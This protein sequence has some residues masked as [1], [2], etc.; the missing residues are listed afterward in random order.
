MPHTNYHRLALLQYPMGATCQGFRWPGATVRGVAPASAPNS[1]GRH[2]RA[3]V[4]PYPLPV[5][6]ARKSPQA[7]RGNLVPAGT[8]STATRLPRRCTP[9]DDKP[10]THEA[11]AM[12]GRSRPYSHYLATKVTGEA[13]L[14]LTVYSAPGSN[15]E[16]SG[17]SDSTMGKSV[18]QTAMGSVTS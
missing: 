18:V 17:T 11:T 12:R 6:R 3:M 15:S 16:P 7:E 9:R 14:T 1:P 8:I 10:S 4:Q 2:C 13:S 5:G